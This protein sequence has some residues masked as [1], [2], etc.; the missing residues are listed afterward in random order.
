MAVLIFIV[1]IIQDFFG[2]DDSP[3]AS[4]QSVLGTPLSWVRPGTD[5]CKIHSSAGRTRER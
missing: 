3:P 4:A 2:G 5:N 1:A